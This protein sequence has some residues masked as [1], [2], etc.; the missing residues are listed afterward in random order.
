M[1]I[2]IEDV[3]ATVILPPMWKGYSCKCCDTDLIIA[4]DEKI[5]FC[6]VCR[7]KEI[8]ETANEKEE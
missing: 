2:K 3:K 4:C 7:S 5:T 8:K 6:P 1:P